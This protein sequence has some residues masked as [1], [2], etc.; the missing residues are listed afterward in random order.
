MV[1]GLASGG[2]ASVTAA[3]IVP[4]HAYLRRTRIGVAK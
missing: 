2:V 1:G 3:G 4:V